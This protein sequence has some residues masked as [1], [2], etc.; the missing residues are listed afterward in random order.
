MTR[1][2]CI[3]EMDV[4]V[5][6]TAQDIEQNHRGLLNTEANQHHGSAAPDGGNVDK[7]M[8][9]AQREVHSLVVTAALSLITKAS[10]AS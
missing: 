8:S 10:T 4:M 9:I 7:F 1:K 3:F 2:V 5:N 6:V